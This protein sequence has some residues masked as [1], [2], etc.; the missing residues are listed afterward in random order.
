MKNHKLRC[1]AFGVAVCVLLASS[2]AV[3]SEEKKLPEDIGKKQKLGRQDALSRAAL[4]AQLAMEGEKRKSPILLLAAAE[5]LGGLKES[6][7]KTEPIEVQGK[8]DDSKKPPKLDVAHLVELARE[9]TKGDDE[10]AAL[11]DKRLEKLSQRGL[12]YEQ[13]KD[14]EDI[15]LEGLNFKVL[16]VGVVGVG[17]Y[18]RLDNV[19]FDAG[20]PAVIAVVGDGDGDLDLGV[21]DGRTERLI[22]KD[23]DYSSVCVVDWLPSAQRPHTVL[24]VNEGKIAERFVVLANW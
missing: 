10:L 8:Q 1:V 15:K 16:Y 20:R 9:Y 3:K 13:G 24:V 17:Q 18:L 19:I 7:R 22:G 14:L 12:I 5:L 2:P 6:A 11:V 21:F 23:D 4:A